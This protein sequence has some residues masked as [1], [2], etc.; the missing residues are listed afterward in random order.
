[1]GHKEPDMTEQ[2]SHSADTC[3]LPYPVNPVIRIEPTK[4][5]HE[6]SGHGGRVGGYVQ[7]QQHGHLLTRSTWLESL[8][9]VQSSV[10]NLCPIRD[11]Q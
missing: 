10:S 7:A 3:Q 1:M 6:Q 4:W 8:P 11:Q 9:S 5:A 2:P